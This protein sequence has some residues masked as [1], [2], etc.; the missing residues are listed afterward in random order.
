MDIV[1]LAKQTASAINIAKYIKNSQDIMDKSEQKLKLAELIEALADIKMETAEIKS[2]LLEKDEKILELEKKLNLKESL[3]Y[4]KPYYW[5]EKK[6]INDGPFCQKCYDGN[7]KLI[8]L[9]GGKNGEWN[10]LSCDNNFRDKTFV[11]QS[12]D[13]SDFF[14]D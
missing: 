11:Y 8:R 6:D 4:D 9:Q 5:I 10:C 3:I 2:T 7:K 1:L 13:T 14:D 12:I